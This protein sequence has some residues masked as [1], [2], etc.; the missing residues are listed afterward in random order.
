MAKVIEPPVLVS[1][2]LMFV[3]AASV[4]V[5]ATLV[6]SLYNMAPLTRPEVFFLMNQSRNVNYVLKQPKLKDS[7]KQIQREYIKGFIRTY[8][9]ARNSLEDSRFT[10]IERWNSIV[11]PWSSESVYDA[12]SKTD[13]YKDIMYNQKSNLVCSIDFSKG[14]VEK[15]TRLWTV[16]FDRT[17]FDKNSGRQIGPKSYKIGIEIQ[18]YLD[19]ESDKTLSYLEDLRNN[20]LGIQITEYR[21]LNTTGTD[22]LSD[23]ETDFYKEGM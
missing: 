23:T 1:R 16:T 7:D 20:P 12:F 21:V 18:S 2:T 10:T 4:A 9:I 14:N 22:P 5:L 17:C 6:F 11:K 8:I 19:S 15:Q 3:L 13:A